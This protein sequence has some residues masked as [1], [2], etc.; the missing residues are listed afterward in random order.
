MYI[1]CVSQQTPAARLEELSA[2]LVLCL[3]RLNRA[4]GRDTVG[5]STTVPTASL[6]LLAQVEELGPAT[7]GALA[8][9]DHCSQPTM[10]GAVAG[11]V[12]RGWATK[13]PNPDDARSSLVELT[14]E[15]RAVLDAARRERAAVVSARAR[16]DGRHDERDL[17]VT[18]AVLRGLLEHDPNEEP[19]P[20]QHDMLEGA[21]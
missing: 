14:D 19:R 21:R 16:A 6:R 13:S 4:I 7:V 11:L 1:A 5:L 15:G 12:Q 2:E 3:G 8:R 9:A 20:V 18:V 17:A 10:S